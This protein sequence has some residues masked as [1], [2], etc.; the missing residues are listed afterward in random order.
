[1]KKNYEKKIRNAWIISFV[2]YFI[3]CLIYSLIAM[4]LINIG[5]LYWGLILLAPLVGFI[6]AAPI[7]IREE[8]I[9]R[10][11]ERKLKEEAR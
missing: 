2:S 4:L 7:I 1:M 8:N 3:G 10:H 11:F 5:G 9:I 6:I